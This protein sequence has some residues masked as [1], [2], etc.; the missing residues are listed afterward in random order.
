MN[1]EREACKQA[2]LQQRGHPPTASASTYPIQFFQTERATDGKD[3]AETGL[4]PWLLDLELT[5]AS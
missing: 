2:K 3:L 4:D 1:G 5:E